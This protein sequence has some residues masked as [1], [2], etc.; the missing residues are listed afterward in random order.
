MPKLAERWNDVGSKLEIPEM[1]TSLLDSLL[2]DARSQPCNCESW[3]C[4]WKSISGWWFGRW[5]LWLSIY[6]EFHNP[7]WRTPSC[8][9]GVA[10]NHQPYIIRIGKIPRQTI[11]LCRF[12]PFFSHAMRCELR[13]RYFGRH[14][15]SGPASE[16]E[17]AGLDQVYCPNYPAKMRY[18]NGLLFTQL[19]IIQII[20][21]LQTWSY[22]YPILPSS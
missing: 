11:P 4:V 15:G 7:N 1:Q 22:Y 17:G 19:E 2:S 18:A 10:K 12:R 8:V 5:M 21:L 6:W 20:L 16:A 9:G 14:H 3:S 13:R